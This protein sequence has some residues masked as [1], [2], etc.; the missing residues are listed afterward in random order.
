VQDFLEEELLRREKQDAF[1]GG[2][3]ELFRGGLLGQ[4]RSR[5]RKVMEE[6]DSLERKEQ[7]SLWEGRSRTPSLMEKKDSSLE[8]GGGL[9]GEVEARGGTGLHVEVK[10]R[11]P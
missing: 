5:T 1:G 4:G 10:S 9:N 3:R 2:E 8:R 11:T 7:D 6:E